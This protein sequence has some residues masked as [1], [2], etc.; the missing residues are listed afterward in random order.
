MRKIKLIIILT[1]IV[2][3]TFGQKEK[4]E[5]ISLLFDFVKQNEHKIICVK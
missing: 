3:Y 1:L 4:K 2:N 5:K